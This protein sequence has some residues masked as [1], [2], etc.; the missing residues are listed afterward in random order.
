M[1]E[2]KSIIEVKHARKKKYSEQD[3][4]NEALEVRDEL[5]ANVQFLKDVI[6]EDRIKM[7]RYHERFGDL[8]YRPIVRDVGSIEPSYGNPT[9]V[10]L[11]PMA[12]KFRA[13]LN[14]LLQSIRLIQSE[15]LPE[16]DPEGADSS[17]IKPTDESAVLSR[18][19]LR[20]EFSSQA[21]TQGKALEPTLEEP[22]SEEVPTELVKKAKPLTKAPQRTTIESIPTPE[23]KS[24]PKPWRAKTQST[25]V[26]AKELPQT[27]EP[28]ITPTL[29]NPNKLDPESERLRAE[30]MGL[31]QSSVSRMSQLA[32]KY[33]KP[34][35]KKY[36]IEDDDAD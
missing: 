30:L 3:V 28:V 10:T 29:Q 9:E 31:R 2:N 21:G 7:E 27:P 13:T 4:R 11:E 16:P 22:D 33:E 26:V 20:E 1:A 36:R 35:G 32:A 18:K 6:R 12:S 24:N 17:R 8:Q 19:S 25:L 14:S 15:I 34:A 23:P 5:L